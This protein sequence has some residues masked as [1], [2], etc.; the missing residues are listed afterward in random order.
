MATLTAELVQGL[1]AYQAETTIGKLFGHMSD[2]HDLVVVPVSLTGDGSMF[3]GENA[4]A[5]PA[6]CVNSK[7]DIEQKT[8][9]D[10]DGKAITNDS[11]VKEWMATLLR[12]RQAEFAASKG[13]STPDAW[14]IGVVEPD[15]PIDML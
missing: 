11:V 8:A 14:N 4:P 1:R 9:N 13:Y 15:V 2:A 12:V 7:N 5:K 10:S 3:S 6:Q